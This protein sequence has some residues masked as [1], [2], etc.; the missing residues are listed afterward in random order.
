[1][2]SSKLLMF[3]IALI[4][5]S[6][7]TVA[8]TLNVRIEP[9][10]NQNI[11]AGETFLMNVF[12]DPVGQAEVTILSARVVLTVSGGFEFV[13][14][15]N[16]TELLNTGVYDIENSEHV[17]L[18][19]LDVNQVIN[20][21]WVISDM[22]NN[23]AG[24]IELG[25]LAIEQQ[26]SRADRRLVGQI[27]LRAPSSGSLQ[28]RLDQQASE[29]LETMEQPHQVSQVLVRQITMMTTTTDST[30]GTQTVT[31]TIGVSGEL[32]NTVES[33]A[34]PRPVEIS[35]GE[36]NGHSSGGGGSLT[37]RVLW[38]CGVWSQCAGNI[39][40]RSCDDKNNCETT[41]TIRGRTYPVFLI[42]G[43]RPATEQSCAAPVGRSSAVKVVTPPSPVNVVTQSPQS[44]SSNSGSSGSSRGQ[45]D[46]GSG[47][48][49]KT[50]PA[51]VPAI[52]PAE[53][54]SMTELAKTTP[55]GSMAGQ[56]TE[57]S[58]QPKSSSIQQPES[59][60]VFS[61]WQENKG[62]AVA[63]IILFIVIAVIIGTMLYVKKKK[64]VKMWQEV[65]TPSP[66]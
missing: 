26:N 23:P 19:P 64:E 62:A 17:F 25:Q 18:V 43:K 28:L 42:N 55:G 66:K 7:S 41:K 8:S 40:T 10:V 30:P 44:T 54:V 27:R 59:T 34:V 33:L 57:P 32:Q 50:V 63:G 36:E 12:L 3:V 38:S 65:M 21:Q 16:P 46:G 15:V 13:Q 6:L 52:V 39:R 48:V 11:V 45:G 60:G 14:V 22:E 2:P 56:K 61:F 20:D 35:G 49:K 9:A 37:C 5:L 1:M 47:L 51:K 24:R 29:F 31:R 58:L 4:V 53:S